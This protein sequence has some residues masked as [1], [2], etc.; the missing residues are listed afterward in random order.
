[1]FDLKTMNDVLVYATSG[2]TRTVMLW[3]DGA[4]WKPITSNELYGRI[5]SLTATLQDWG[6][7]K[8]DR[9]ALLSENRWEWPVCDFAAL[10][11]GAVDVPLYAHTHAGASWLHA[12]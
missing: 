8:G 2:G 7:A 4:A 12:A 11:L 3:Q 6:V 5:R 10:A 9:I 1:M